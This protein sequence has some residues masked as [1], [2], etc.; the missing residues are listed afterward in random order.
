LPDPVHD[1]VSLS[2]LIFF[3]YILV[4]HHPPQKCMDTHYYQMQYQI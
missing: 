3:I 2:Q 1:G 4:V